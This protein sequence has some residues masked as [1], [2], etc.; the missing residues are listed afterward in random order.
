MNNDLMGEKPCTQAHGS[1]LENTEKGNPC[2]LW[3]V[4]FTAVF[5]FILFRFFVHLD[6]FSLGNKNGLGKWG[7]K[8]FILSGQQ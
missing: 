1:F 7:S 8:S 2:M 3:L 4:N 5:Y 6:L